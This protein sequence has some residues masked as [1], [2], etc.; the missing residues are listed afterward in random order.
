MIF[1]VHLINFQIRFSLKQSLEQKVFLFHK[2][3]PHVRLYMLFDHTLYIDN[4][5]S[6]LKRKSNKSRSFKIH[7]S[8]LT[9]LSIQRYN[10]YSSLTLFFCSILR[11]YTILPMTYLYCQLLFAIDTMKTHQISP[12]STYNTLFCNLLA[13]HQTI[14]SITRIWSSKLPL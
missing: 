10:F 6:A 9:Y 4:K 11:A 7:S 5:Y 8:Q 3:S 1:Q 12:F 14:P 2:E 13:F